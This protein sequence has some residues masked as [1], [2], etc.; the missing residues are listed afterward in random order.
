[1][2]S[3]RART[4]EL[5]LWRALEAICNGLALIIRLLGPALIFAAVWVIWGLYGTMLLVGMV[6]TL[7]IV[8]Q[9]VVAAV[10]FEMRAIEQRVMGQLRTYAQ[11][12]ESELIDG[13]RDGE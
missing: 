13:R 1:M 11:R 2:A 5:C 8:A 10:H 4:L 6:M 9:M 12:L 3:Q 7:R